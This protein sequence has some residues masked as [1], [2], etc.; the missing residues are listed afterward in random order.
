MNELI[1][2]YHHRDTTGDAIQ[3][4]VAGVMVGVVIA[5]F[6]GAPAG[7]PVVIC[8]SCFF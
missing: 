6:L 2:R 8:L 4:F 5:A 7:A 1:L 3:V